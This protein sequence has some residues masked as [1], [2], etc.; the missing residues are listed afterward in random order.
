MPKLRWFYKKKM[1]VYTLFAFDFSVEV[2]NNYVLSAWAR[3][4][5]KYFSVQLGWWK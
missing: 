3:L 5:W 2:G 1:Q 4:G